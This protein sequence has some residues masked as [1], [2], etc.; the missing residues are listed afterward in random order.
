L[1]TI[2]FELDDIHGST[3]LIQSDNKKIEK[4]IYFYKSLLEKIEDDDETP[5]TLKNQIHSIACVQINKLRKYTYRDILSDNV[6]AESKAA[7]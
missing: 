1:F 3:M 5:D 7:E 2:I 4:N 6:Q